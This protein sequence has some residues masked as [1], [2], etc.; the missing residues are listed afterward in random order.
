M[1]YKAWIP[2]VSGNL[3]FSN[4]RGSKI[5]NRAKA[6]HTFNHIANEDNGW[7][8]S[9]QE[10]DLSD[11]AFPNRDGKFYYLLKANIE[12]RWEQNEILRGYV[13]TYPKTQ[14]TQ[15]EKKLI[16]T[17]K[18][19]VFDSN[20]I[21]KLLEIW[22]QKS[23]FIQVN[24]EL[25]RDGF[26]DLNLEQSLDKEISYSIV[27]ESYS[28]LKDLIHAHKFHRY[29]DDA[30]VVPYPDKQDNDLWIVKTLRN[31]HRSVVFSYRNATHQQDI[32]N[33]L[34]KLSYLDSFQN[35]AKNKYGDLIRKDNWID[36]GIL[37]TS[38]DLKLRDKESLENN[39]SDLQQ[40]LLNIIL[41]LFG[42]IIAMTQLLQVPCIDGL[43]YDS[44]CV[45][46]DQK[47]MF[48]LDTGSLGYVQIILKYWTQIALSM[49]IVI[50]ILLI[51]VNFWRIDRWLNNNIGHSWWGGYI[52]S[53]L[54]FAVSDK[55]GILLAF[56]WVIIFA[57]IMVSLLMVGLG[58]FHPSFY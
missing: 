53:I 4:I 22:K 2:N 30:I 16:E 8:Y 41:S 18:A 21:D 1:L 7:I 19:D 31:L 12:R 29:D 6:P 48:A 57:V 56:G 40:T 15:E 58:L 23:F 26:I 5:P 49:P 46:H 32:L 34:G 3:S 27:F 11:G 50:G 43:T 55:C 35:I 9:L 52:R 20:Q 45:S 44:S 14:L 51:M 25:S 54:A 38:L 28:F 13:I 24:F 47:F 36:T 33:A 37:K 39:K 17:I 10:R 42:L